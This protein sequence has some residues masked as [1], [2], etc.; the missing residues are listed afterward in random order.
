MTHYYHVLSPIQH[1]E[2][3]KLFRSQY[4]GTCAIGRAGGASVT[5]QRLN[6]TQEQVDE[7]YWILNNLITFFLNTC[8]FSCLGGGYYENQCSEGT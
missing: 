6:M 2:L 4:S 3:L 5:S 1:K 8:T 7:V